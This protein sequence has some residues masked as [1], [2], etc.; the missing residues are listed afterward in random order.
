MIGRHPYY[1]GVDAIRFVAALLVMVYHLG[2]W[3]WA[4]NGTTA[5]IFNGAARFESATSFTWFG[6]VGVEIFFVIS[7]FVIANSA[8]E[9]SAAAFLRGR[10]LRL[11]P[12]AWICA[13]ST[14]VFMVLGNGRF[15]SKRS[16]PIAKINLD[17]SVPGSG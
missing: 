1:S 12:A 8:N 3:S 13:T 17:Q 9:A 5:R 10:I 6:W 15:I 11:Y 16:S 2:F 7:G 4:G 14:A